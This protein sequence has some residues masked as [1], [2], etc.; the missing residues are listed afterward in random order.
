MPTAFWKTL[1]HPQPPPPLE[2][3]VILKVKNLDYV[4]FRVHV[5]DF[6]IRVLSCK[7]C[8]IKIIPDNKV[9]RY[10]LSRLFCDISMGMLC[11]YSL[12]PSLCRKIA[13]N[14]NV[15]NTNVVGAGNPCKTI[16]WRAIQRKSS[17]HLHALLFPLFSYLL[18]QQFNKRAHTFKKKCVLTDTRKQFV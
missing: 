15:Y 2:N 3:V 8:V 14:N 11:S 6:G 13:P 5:L 16:F 18:Q 9:N 10:H 12:E 7:I 1:R 4:I 17:H